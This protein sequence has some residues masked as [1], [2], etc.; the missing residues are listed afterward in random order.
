MLISLSVSDLY[1]R[2]FEVLMQKLHT[3]KLCWHIVTL[4]GQ[5][6]LISFFAADFWWYVF[7]GNGTISSI[8]EISGGISI[9][10]WVKKSLYSASV[11]WHL[12][13]SYQ[14]TIFRQVEKVF[15]S[16]LSLFANVCWNN[17]CFCSLSLI[18]MIRWIQHAIA[19][20][21]D[22]IEGPI[23]CTGGGA[24]KYGCLIAETLRVE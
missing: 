12:R 18:D 1:S 22:Q 11:R 15:G 21:C 4:D 19:R 16:R 14:Q 24:Y 8:E 23:R 20:G 13:K 17:W 9:K 2:V 6:A 5:I 7:D 3:G 10:R